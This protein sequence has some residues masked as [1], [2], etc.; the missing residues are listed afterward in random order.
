MA[1]YPGSE[2]TRNLLLN[3]NSRG[4]SEEFVTLDTGEDKDGEETWQEGR[5]PDA[6][7]SGASAWQ[8]PMG[9][10]LV[11]FAE[12]PAEPDY[13]AG[14][15]TGPSRSGFYEQWEGRSVTHD[16]FLQSYE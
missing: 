6:S 13:E 4:L 11:E 1:E 12:E 9:T 15:S 8:A 10:D 7:A 3:V 14:I 16:Y 2:W 5:R